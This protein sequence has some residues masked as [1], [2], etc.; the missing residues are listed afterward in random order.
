MLLAAVKEI[1]MELLAPAGNLEKLSYAYT[2]GA[3]AAYIGIKNFS[4]RAR[5]DNFSSE[6]YKDIKAIKGNRKL[7]G[8]LNIFFQNSDIQNLEENIDYISH[9]PL[10]AFIIS[11]L[12]ILKLLQKRFPS[13][14]L[15]LSTQANCINAESAKIYR[16]LGFSRIILGRETPLREISF[17]RK[18][19]PDVELEVFVH[20]AMCLAYSGRC[21]L[22]SYMA[23]RSANQGDCSHS[24]RWNYR[25]LEEGKRPGEYYPVVEGE[26]F[27]S[28]LSSKDL[29]MIDYLKELKDTGVDSLKIEG[30]MK[31]LYYTSVITRAYRK[32]IDALES[33]ALASSW[34]PYR[35][36]L[37]K[38][39]HREFSTGF[40]FKPEDM[41]ETTQKSYSR[42]YMFLGTIG[43]QLDAHRYEI[44]VKNQ[45][46]TE[47]DSL[48][49]IGPDLPFIR[50]TSV[51]LFDETNA[52]VT[53]A[54]HGKYYTIQSSVPIKPGFIVRKKIHQ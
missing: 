54:D 5:A 15:H 8:A 20:G 33:G 11:D 25:V 31:S 2:Y 48:E 41:N 18:A 38:V 47:E 45:I 17:I 52:P 26:N 35:D 16:D 44:H 29:C 51:K 24:C 22:S 12:G 4:L 6:E 3:D 32:A 37:E 40:F 1:S 28:I 42:E 36:E 50:D 39:S 9:Y 10:D 53:K 27:T 13:I 34:K 49:F 46:K 30:R 43:K 23:G 19:V 14:P 7:F 21:F